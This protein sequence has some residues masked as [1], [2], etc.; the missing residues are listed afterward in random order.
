MNLQ[1]PS[2]ESAAT[3]EAIREAKSS[4]QGG[5]VPVIAVVPEQA[6]VSQEEAA[7][8]VEAG[9]DGIALPLERMQQAAASFSGRTDREALNPVRASQQSSRRVSCTAYDTGP[10]TNIMASNFHRDLR[11]Q[12]CIDYTHEDGT[13]STN[14]YFVIT[15]LPLSIA[16]TIIS[17]AGY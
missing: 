5:S 1:G 8:L 13:H 2:R 14:L 6:S 15:C 17:F 16:R 12:S 3:S 7:S 11:H 9:P 4:Q 10:R